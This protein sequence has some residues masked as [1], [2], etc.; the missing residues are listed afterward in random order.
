[1]SDMSNSH[2]LIN[3]ARK[4]PLSRL[5][6]ASEDF[7]L[8]MPPPI[9]DLLD[10]DDPDLDHVIRSIG[11]LRA[12]G[13]DTT[14]P[15]VLEL[16]V[17][18][19]RNLARAAEEQGHPDLVAAREAEAA[20]SNEYWAKRR[21]ALSVVYYARLGNRVKIGYT[22]NLANR[23]QNIQPEELLATERGGEALESRRHAQFDRLR[24]SGEWFRYEQPLIDHI[25]GLPTLAAEQP[26]RLPSDL[27]RLFHRGASR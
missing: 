26:P 21:A 6:M 7:S 19:G 12:A 22:T 16:A 27:A 3:A 11:H 1:M 17:T 18:G 13:L 4:R 8:L 25:A 2:Q 10:A 5:T 9:L 23:M 14:D 15:A 24:V 20:E